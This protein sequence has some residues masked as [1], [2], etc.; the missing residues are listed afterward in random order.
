MNIDNNIN[1]ELIIHKYN[2]NIDKENI[3]ESA[4]TMKELIIKK[5]I[6]FNKK[7]FTKTLEK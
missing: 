6:K 1:N 2:K 5:D 3:I 4:Q 7:R